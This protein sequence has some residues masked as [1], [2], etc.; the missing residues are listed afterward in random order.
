MPG[1]APVPASTQTDPVPD[2]YSGPVCPPPPLVV[3]PDTCVHALEQE[4]AAL[5]SAL[6]AV[7]D[8]VRVLELN[9]GLAIRIGNARLETPA[10]F[11]CNE[12]RPGAADLHML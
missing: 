2:T 7:L 5:R 3:M 4:C 11:P 10:S 8:R 9:H 6:E 12:A 1:P